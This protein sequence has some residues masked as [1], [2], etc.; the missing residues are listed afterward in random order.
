MVN[1]PSSPEGFQAPDAV[2]FS[3]AP[4]YIIGNEKLPRSSKFDLQIEAS[5]SP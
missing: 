3:S 5:T 2:K 4:G 1:V